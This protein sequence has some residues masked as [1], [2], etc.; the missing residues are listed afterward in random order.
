VTAAPSRRLGRDGPDVFPLGLGCMGMSG[1]Y[2]LARKDEAS[3]GAASRAEFVRTIHYALGRGM[4][5]LDTADIYGPFRNEELVGEAIRGRRERLV[6]ATKFG[7]EATADGVRVNGR[8]EYARAAC[9]SSLLRLGVETIDLY[10]LHRVDPTVPIEDT[11][12][13]MAELVAEGKVRYIGL[14]EVGAETIRRAQA[15]HPISAVQTE[16][17]L[18]SREPEVRIF[19]TLVELGI[20]FVP[21]A[22]LGRGF[23]AGAVTSFD[24]LLDEDFRRTLP[25]FHNANLAKNLEL[26]QRMRALAEERGTTPARLAL[27][28]VL[29][30][31]D[32]IVPIF[33]TTR[34]EHLD[35]DLGAVDLA[36]DA[37]ALH[38]IGE[39]V[40]PE[41]VTGSR[42]ADMSLIE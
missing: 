15:V 38:T 11:V 19:P 13:A 21:Y 27:A 32:F 1:Y 40:P 31:G 37:D 14:S 25:R 8:P 6:L 5:F 29:G 7:F 20:G 34:R 35:D 22:A 17:S 12:G 2:G 16:Y 9:E 42:Y 30:R 36:L 18:W 41:S 39:T 33:G 26:A 24:E 28:W 3:S 4:D 23:F 10:Y